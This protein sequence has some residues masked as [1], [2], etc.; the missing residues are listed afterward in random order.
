MRYGGAAGEGQ[1]G[2]MGREG[3]AWEWHERFRVREQRGS[4]DKKGRG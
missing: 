4:E 3:R 1:D 2:E